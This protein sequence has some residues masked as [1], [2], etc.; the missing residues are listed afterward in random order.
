MFQF[1]D[2]WNKLLLGKTVRIFIVIFMTC[3]FVGNIAANEEKEIVISDNSRLI[4]NIQETHYN[5]KDPVIFSAFENKNDSWSSNWNN[6]FSGD[7]IENFSE[8]LNQKIKF[9][10][11]ADLSKRSKNDKGNDSSSN[12]LKSMTYPGWGG[13]KLVKISFS[14][15]NVKETAQWSK[16]PLDPKLLKLVAS[17]FKKRYPKIS[18]QWATT[19]LKILECYFNAKNNSWLIGLEMS[20]RKSDNDGIPDPEFNPNWFYINKDV[21]KFIGVNLY[22]LLAFTDT[23]NKAFWLMGY[24]GYNLEGYVLWDENFNKNNYFLYNF[25]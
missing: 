10:S 13:D 8:D 2:I 14:E 21:I 4:L 18:Y 17:G 3:L 6:L 7:S 24:S 5:E 15:S 9:G 19:D 1:N 16:R 22:P 23:S 11:L 20:S 12:L 25:H